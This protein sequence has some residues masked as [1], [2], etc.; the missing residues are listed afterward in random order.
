MHKVLDSGVYPFSTYLFVGVEYK[1]ILK[2]L[3]KHKIIPPPEVAKE[4]DMP[5]DVNGRT[6]LM[7]G[8]HTALLLRKLEY[9]VLAHELVH[10]CVYI[11]GTVGIPINDRTDE[12]MAY[13]MAHLYRQAICLPQPRRRKK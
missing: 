9:P 3:K 2:I 13:L 12:A 6:V 4:F 11:L 1:K 10:V 8:G 7:P 5:D